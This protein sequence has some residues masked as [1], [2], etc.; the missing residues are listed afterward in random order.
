MNALVVEELLHLVSDAHVVGEV[1]AADVGRGDDT[2]ASQLPD[3]E[4][5]H[6]DH[7]RHLHTHTTRCSVPVST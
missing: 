2:I 7:T 5:V 1:L 6:R 3:V 4:L